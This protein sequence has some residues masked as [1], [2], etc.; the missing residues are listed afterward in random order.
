MPTEEKPGQALWLQPKT[1]P[2]VQTLDNGSEGQC[3]VEPAAILP[4]N[5]QEEAGAGCGEKQERLKFLAEVTQQKDFQS[6]ALHSG[7]GHQQPSQ[8]QLKCP[9]RG[10]QCC[11][12]LSVVGGTLRHTHTQ[13]S[14]RDICLLHFRE[15]MAQKGTERSPS[16]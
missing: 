11:Y 7:V 3:R 4:K 15:A 10:S 14:D 13:A 9:T 16:V 1:Q 8:D 2:C 6:K 5:P 12:C